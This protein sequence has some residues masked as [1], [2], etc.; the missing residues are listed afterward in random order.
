MQKKPQPVN[1]GDYD[2]STVADIKRFIRSNA[3]YWRQMRNY[4][5]DNDFADIDLVTYDAYVTAYGWMGAALACVILPSD[6]MKDETP[7]AVGDEVP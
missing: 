1:R 3:T 7:T 6:L 5:E 2:L 4:A